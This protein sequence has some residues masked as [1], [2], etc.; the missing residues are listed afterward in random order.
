M[1]EPLVWVESAWLY[2][3]RSRGQARP[4][5]DWDLA[6]LVCGQPSLDLLQKLQ[7]DLEEAVAGQVSLAI[8]NRADTLLS[9][10]A[11]SGQLLLRR[12]AEKHAQF[13]SRV[14]RLA[15]DDQIRLRRALG[16]WREAHARQP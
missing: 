5:S 14:C 7:E 16:W 12:D 4:D 2:G 6:V 10:E 8:L 13:V 9:R 1:L 15:E 3:S 11:I